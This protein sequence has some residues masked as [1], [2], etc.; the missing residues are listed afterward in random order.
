MTT[1]TPPEFYDDD[2]SL[3]LLGSESPTAME[4]DDLADMNLVGLLRAA[5]SPSTDHKDS[6]KRSAR[7]TISLLRYM[8]LE[9]EAEKGQDMNTSILGGLNGFAGALCALNVPQLRTAKFDIHIGKGDNESGSRGGSKDDAC[10]L[11]ALILAKHTDTDYE[12]PKPLKL[13]DFLPESTSQAEFET[14]LGENATPE[15]RRKVKDNMAV[16]ESGAAISPSASASD[17]KRLSVGFGGGKDNP[18]G[19]VSDE[20]SDEDGDGE[21]VVGIFGK[22]GEPSRRNLMAGGGGGNKEKG[23]AKTGGGGGGADANGKP[24]R[25]T[26]T[27]MATENLKASASPAIFAEEEVSYTFIHSCYGVIFSFG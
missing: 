13:Q 21:D 4:D 9:F 19:D 2:Y 17:G 5:G 27:T 25:W 12:T 10:H 8:C 3:L 14:W 6:L 1:K 11:L 7:P 20:D 24:T 18:F 16:A 26:E 23:G 15:V 22:K